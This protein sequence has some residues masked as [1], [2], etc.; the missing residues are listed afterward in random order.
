M[1]NYP[2]SDPSFSAK[3][4]GNTIQAAHVNALQDEVVAI[5]SALR[6]G[7]SHALIV[8]TGGLTVSTGSVNVGGPSSVATL[9]VNGTS[10]FT[11]GA[12]FSGDLSIGGNLTVTGSFALSTPRVKVTHSANQEVANGAF[13]GLSWD[14]ELYDSTGMHSTAANSSRITFASTGVYHVGVAIVWNTVAATGARTV[15]LRL[16]D[17]TGIA[18]QRVTGISGFPTPL[19]VSADVRIASTADYVTAIAHQNSGST[20]SVMADGG[21]TLGAT[22]FWARKVSS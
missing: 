1:A 4:A 2:T 7:L 14:T 17:A 15:G 8:S 16:N 12:T 3:S 9:Q 21:S 5:G 19:M 13:A 11:G 18:A 20:L 10:T 6:S 22:V